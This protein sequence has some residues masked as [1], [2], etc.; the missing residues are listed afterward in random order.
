MSILG[1]QHPQNGCM[2]RRHQDDVT[3]A[4]GGHLIRMPLIEIDLLLF[5]I[6]RDK[7][8]ALGYISLRHMSQNP[9]NTDK[10][11]CVREQVRRKADPTPTRN[12]GEPKGQQSQNRSEKVVCF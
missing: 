5:L 2:T 12:D 4:L 8:V 1:L 9:G 3:S 10:C 6:P 7:T 11:I